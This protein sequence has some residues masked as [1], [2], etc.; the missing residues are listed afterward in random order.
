MRMTEHTIK[1]VNLRKRLLQYTLVVLSYD[2]IVIIHVTD[3][4]IDHNQ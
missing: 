1:M 2:V 4:K 3:I